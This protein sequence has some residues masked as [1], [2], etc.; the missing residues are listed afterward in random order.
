M[1]LL[2]TCIHEWKSIFILKR[3]KKSAQAKSLNTKINK[4]TAWLWSYFMKLPGSLTALDNLQKYLCAVFSCR[5]RLRMRIILLGSVFYKGPFYP[6]SSTNSHG[7]FFI[8]LF[9]FA[10]KLSFYVL[11]WLIWYSKTLHYVLYLPTAWTYL[12]QSTAQDLNTVNICC[13]HKQTVNRETRGK[14][15]TGNVF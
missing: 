9:F 6:A 15:L 3:G 2:L 4:V 12:L 13:A 7:N 8:K 11:K 10:W 14:I 1:T 5:K